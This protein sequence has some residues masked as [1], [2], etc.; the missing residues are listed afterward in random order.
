M[1]KLLVFLLICALGYYL[2]RS[3][4]P[5]PGG[6]TRPPDRLD[7]SQAVDADFEESEPR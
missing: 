5:R 6:R 3:L 4:R 1:L 7:P 2:W